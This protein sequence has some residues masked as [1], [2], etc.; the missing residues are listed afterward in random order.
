M[1]T[2]KK[3]KSEI[4]RAIRTPVQSLFFN[5]KISLHFSTFLFCRGKNGKFSVIYGN[6]FATKGDLLPSWMP[7]FVKLY[8]F[9]VYKFNNGTEN[10]YKRID[11]DS[12]RNITVMYCKSVRKRFL[13]SMAA[14]FF[15]CFCFYKCIAKCVRNIDFWG[16]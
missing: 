5:G 14:H 16:F 15:L 11:F 1:G 2:G 3:K 4:T 7:I 8:F 6:F 13:K 10:V 9:S 12:M